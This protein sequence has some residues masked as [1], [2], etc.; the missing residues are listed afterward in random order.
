MCNMYPFNRHS[1]LVCAL[2]RCQCF[3]GFAVLCV[4]EFKLT[5]STPEVETFPF[6]RMHRFGP[7]Q[8]LEPFLLGGDVAS[9]YVG[10]NALFAGPGGGLVALASLLFLQEDLI[11]WVLIFP[12]GSKDLFRP[13]RQEFLCLFAAMVL[14]LTGCPD[15]RVGQLGRFFPTQLVRQVIDLLSPRVFRTHLPDMGWNP[16]HFEAVDI[17]GLQLPP[18]VTVGLARLWAADSFRDTKAV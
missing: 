4:Q 3:Q 11:H 5:L 1:A 18:D 7:D 15:I 10:A 16:F 6:P 8:L 14:V 2:V 12:N 13:A 17:C 9:P